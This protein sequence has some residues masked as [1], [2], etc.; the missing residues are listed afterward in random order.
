[1]FF[2]SGRFVYL[3]KKESRDFMKAKLCGMKTLAAAQAAEMAGATFIGFIFW[4]KSHR[5]IAPEQAA[6]IAAKLHRVRTVGVFV[7]EAPERVNAIADEVGLD[8]VQLHGHED[9]AYAEKMKRPVIKAYR[10]GAG[11]DAKEAAVFP[12]DYVLLDS[13]TAKL[14]GGTGKTFAWREAAQAVGEVPELKSRLFIAGGVA[15][16]NVAEIENIF[17]P[18][19][20]DVSGSLEVEREKSIEKIESFMKAV[21]A[22]NAGNQE[23]AAS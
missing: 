23:G 19:G 11:F 10:Y 13:G 8:F 14:P 22:V 15:E 2:L 17:H 18:F 16:D 3:E 6:A 9:A 21:E 12:A 20:V 7:D 5:Y 4:P 1:M